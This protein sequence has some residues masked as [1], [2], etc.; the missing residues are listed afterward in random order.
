M[1]PPVVAAV[2]LGGTRVKLGFVDGSGSVLDHD[3]FDTGAFDG[4]EAL[5]RGIGAEINARKDRFD[6]IGIGIGAPNGNHHRGTVEHPPNLPWPGVTPLASLFSDATGLPAR[7]DNDAN[8]AALGEKRFGAAQTV[9]DFLFVTLGTGVGSGIVVAGNL[10]RG[11]SG[12]AGEVGH[13][14]VE[15]GGRLC[16][17]GRRGCLE[18]YTSATGLVKTYR[19]AVPDAPD[20]ADALYV[21][22]QAQAGDAAARD[23]FETTG[24]ILGLALANSVAYT[25]PEVVF[26][27][28]GLAEAGETL[29]EPIRRH[30]NA[31]L[32]TIYQGTVAIRPSGLP[33]GD[34]ALL[35]AASLVWHERGR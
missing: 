34:A 19:D 35:G 15:P 5:A 22:Q 23:T 6:L 33:S 13:V 16:G 12:F 7:L 21:F 20:D 9:N 11:Y 1:L 10:V 14:I 27:F 30:F 18:Q 17:C 3:A 26:L 29:F 25:S 2:D 31:N 4:P 28:G 32:L 8:A 24:R